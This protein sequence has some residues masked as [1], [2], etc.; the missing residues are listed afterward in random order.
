MLR[1]PYFIISLR[2]E[3]IAVHYYAPTWGLNSGKLGGLPRYC[4]PSF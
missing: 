4:D 1:T 3:E 2:L